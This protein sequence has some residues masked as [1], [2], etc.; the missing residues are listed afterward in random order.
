M[1]V[2]G[3]IDVATNADEEGCVNV[4]VRCRKT[5]L[6]GRGAMQSRKELVGGRGDG[7]AVC[8]VGKKGVI[9][10]GFMLN[11]AVGGAVRRRAMRR[12]CAAVG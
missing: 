8:I 1:L 7:M 2:C 3:E 12:V 6:I 5:G 11:G 10:V 4:V 9:V